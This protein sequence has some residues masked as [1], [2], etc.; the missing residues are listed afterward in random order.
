[1]ANPPT[2]GAKIYERPERKAIS[3][4]MI[5]VLVLVLATVGYLAYRALAPAAQSNR[6]GQAGQIALFLPEQRAT[7]NFVRLA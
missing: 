5:V 2:E 4:L 6:Q 1:M 7:D 3:P